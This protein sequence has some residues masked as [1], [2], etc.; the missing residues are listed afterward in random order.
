M[1]WVE[2]NHLLVLAILVL[3]S[4]FFF[5][6]RAEAGPYAALVAEVETERSLFD[7]NADELRHPASLT[8]M[9]TLYLVFEALAS[10]RIS[11]DTVLRASR[12]AVLR[13][14][15]RLG[16][17]AGDGITVEQGI[18]ALVTRS[19]N[20]AA[21]V[22]AEGMAGSESAFAQLMT[23]KAHQLGMSRT[24]YRNAS[25]LPDPNQVTTAWDMFR[26]GKSLYKHFPQ[27]YP[28]FSTTQ[29]YF[30]GRSFHNHNHLLKSYP[31]ADG[32]KTGFV[33]AS[34]FNLVASARRSG[35]RL[36]GVV[37][38]G[39]SAA[40]R[41]AHMRD[42][43]DDGFAQ[44]DGLEPKVHTASFD[45]PE[46]PT[47]LSRPKLPQPSAERRTGRKDVKLA[48]SGSRPRD[49]GDGQEKAGANRG[50]QIWQVRVGSFPREKAA[51]Q[52]LSQALKVAPH[53]FRHA[54]ATITART[55]S[56]KKV[57]L[58]V[59]NGMT[60]E[61]AAAACQALKRKRMECASGRSSS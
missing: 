31:G 54:R 55:R 10:G 17:N 36:I 32:I 52:R 38:G 9:M 3:A 1:H 30:D 42:I 7:R 21:A 15:S 40:A 53:P 50:K 60:K 8:K 20:D 33:N 61:D 46:P 51:E 41:D 57:Y 37:F 43:L 35:H 56:G 39:T 24:V 28:Y 59:F 47:L 45:Q 16:L 12:F 27:Y 6:Q 44:L 5:T 23:E 11:P 49:E 13:P 34:G 25:G 18:L 4:G 29:F 26:L 14:P 2:H 48:N 22:I 58:A 19:A